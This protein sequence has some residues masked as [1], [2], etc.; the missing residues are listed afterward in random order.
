MYWYNFVHK[1]QTI[2]TFNK[3]ED[4]AKFALGFADK[5]P[6]GDMVTNDPDAVKTWTHMQFCNT[7]EHMFLFGYTGMA[8]EEINKLTKRGK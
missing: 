7:K 1:G 8:E 6:Y 4:C 2:K 3:P 5:V